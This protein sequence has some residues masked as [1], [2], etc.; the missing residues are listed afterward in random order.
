[1][2][3]SDLWTSIISIS[4]NTHYKGIFSTSNRISSRIKQRGIF[5]ILEDFNS[6]LNNYDKLEKSV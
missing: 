4:L 5:S 1:M 6:I 3:N 2:K